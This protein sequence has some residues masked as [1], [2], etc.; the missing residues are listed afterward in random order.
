MYTAAM[1]SMT[2]ETHVVLCENN[3]PYRTLPRASRPP[4]PLEIARVMSFIYELSARASSAYFRRS[5]VFISHRSG[6]TSAR[7]SPV[8]Q[9]SPARFFM[10]NVKIVCGINIKNFLRPRVHGN[11]SLRSLSLSLSLILLVNV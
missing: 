10:A 8:L 3:C 6:S 2:Q 11:K 4:P 9:D 7:I 1:Y 5:V